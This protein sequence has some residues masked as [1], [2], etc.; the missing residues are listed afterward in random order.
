MGRR[1]ADATKACRTR[2]TRGDIVLCFLLLRLETAVLFVAPADLL[3]AR[4]VDVVVAGEV[5]DAE[6]DDAEVDDVEVDDGEDADV[7]VVRIEISGAAVF[8]AVSS[9]GAAVLTGPP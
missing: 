3:A 5:D 9:T 8:T 1:L 6:V 4:F 7:P 2:R